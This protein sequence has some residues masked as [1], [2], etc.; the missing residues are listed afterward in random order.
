MISVVIPAH[1]E[2]NVLSRCL[3]ALLADARP[4]ELEVVVVCNGCQDD[5]AGVAR[6]F[7]DAVQVCEISE[8]SKIAA[9]NEGDA[10]VSGFPRFYL[11]ADIVLGTPE[12]RLVAT[13]LDDN[14]LMAAAPRAVVDLDGAAFGVRSFY[15]VWQRTP[16]YEEGMIG[17]GVYALTELA[18]SRFGIFPDLIAD[19][20]YVRALYAGSERGTVAAASVTIYA[21]RTLR[22]LIKAKT[23]SRLGVYQLAARFPDLV[24]QDQVEKRYGMAIWQIL[25][26]P[27][28]W[29]AIPFY[30]AVNLVARLRA[31]RQLGSLAEYTWERD[32]STR[33]EV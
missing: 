12:L 33:A 16:Y 29:L 23:R 14:R 3:K 7:G 25:T 26:S 17:C 5:T 18:R 13:A 24:E 11:D 2:E 19:D 20:G 9:L 4:G 30:L 6:S 8:A 22:D 15:R 31:R 1:N 21:P 28:L 27:D 10:R 32:D